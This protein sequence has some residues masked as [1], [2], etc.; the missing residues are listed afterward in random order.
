[1]ALDGPRDQ[2]WSNDGELADEIAMYGDLVVAASESQ[3][4]LTVD[5]ID[6]ALGIG[7]ARK[8]GERRAS[9]CT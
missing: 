9:R 6:A 4:T 3:Q 1:M 5:E 8:D 2:G 7:G